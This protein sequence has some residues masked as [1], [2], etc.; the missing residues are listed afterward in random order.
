MSSQSSLVGE[1]DPLWRDTTGPYAGSSELERERE[2]R[3]DE[4]CGLGIKLEERRELKPVVKG[5]AISCVLTDSERLEALS[6]IGLDVISVLA[7][8][9]LISIAASV[10]D[11]VRLSDLFRAGENS[12]PSFPSVKMS[13]S[14]RGQRHGVSPC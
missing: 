8:E 4:P 9:S 5:P 13:D 6:C 7:P 1:K 2:R 3:P 14:C 11:A 12:R 10:S